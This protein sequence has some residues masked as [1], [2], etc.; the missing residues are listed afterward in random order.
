M[1]KE[2]EKKVE[3]EK[4]EERAKSQLVDKPN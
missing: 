1:G 2:W 3:K 4:K